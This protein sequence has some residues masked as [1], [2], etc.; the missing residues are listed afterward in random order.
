[1]PSKKCLGLPGRQDL[2]FFTCSNAAAHMR[3]E[4]LP[5]HGA[6]A[7]PLLTFPSAAPG[8]S[9]ASSRRCYRP[10]RATAA[11]ISAP[12]CV[13]HRSR[14]MQTSKA[15]PC[16]GPATTTP[17]TECSQVGASS[18]PSARRGLDTVRCARSRLSR[19][20]GAGTPGVIGITFFP[21]PGV[22]CA[23]STCSAS[24]LERQR[25]SLGGVL[26]IEPDVARDPR[27]ELADRYRLGVVVRTLRLRQIAIAVEVQ[28]SDRLGEER[29]VAQVD[30]PLLVS[31]ASGGPA[32]SRGRS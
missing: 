19:P 1:M 21:R 24:E 12:K 8:A 2:A 30:R 22:C 28:P 31:E 17:R 15:L 20:G 6:G 4:V 7:A 25:L 23:C 29:V 32:Q 10:W 9:P 26:N 3:L 14:A 16:L 5:L 11:F 27:F 18:R 13:S